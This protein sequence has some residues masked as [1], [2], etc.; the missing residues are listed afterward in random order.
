[1]VQIFVQ[2][3]VWRK[4]TEDVSQDTDP[5]LANYGGL[6][7]FPNPAYNGITFP[8]KNSKEG[9]AQPARNDDDDEVKGNMY[10]EPL[11]GTV[12]YVD[13]STNEKPAYENFKVLY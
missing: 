1:M 7:V 10:V 11:Y 8:T 13:E 4:T 9:E 3:A 6:E 12:H 2:Y 5:T